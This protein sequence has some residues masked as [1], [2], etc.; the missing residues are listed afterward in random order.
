MEVKT[1]TIEAYS[2]SEIQKLESDVHKLRQKNNR[3]RG[4]LQ[5][6]G[7]KTVNVTTGKIET[8]ELKEVRHEERRTYQKLEKSMVN[9][10]R[11]L[12]NQQQYTTQQDVDELRRMSNYHRNSANR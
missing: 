10:E 4:V 11:V 9:E 7:V 3:L 12:S 8:K 6:M 5:Q 2:I 1:Q